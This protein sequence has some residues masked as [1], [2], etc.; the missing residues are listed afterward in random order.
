MR[1][2]NLDDLKAR[3]FYLEFYD[4]D[5]RRYGIPTFP[6]RSAPAGYATIRQLRAQGLRPGGQ[7]VAAQ[8]IWRHRKQHRIAYLYPIKDAKPK[9]T[10]TPAQHAAIQKALKARRT[11]PTCGETKWYYIPRRYGVCLDCAPISH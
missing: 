5:G 10:A 7:P 4:P 11:C 2:P 9:R 3:G 6:W 1:N 8:I